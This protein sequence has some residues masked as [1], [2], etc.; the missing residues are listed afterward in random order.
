MHLLISVSSDRVSV[1]VEP[2]YWNWLMTSRFS[3]SM[4]LVGGIGVAWPMTWVF[5]R[6]MVKLNRLQALEKLSINLCSPS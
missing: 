3:P 2:R 4:V 6:V 5:S 1:V